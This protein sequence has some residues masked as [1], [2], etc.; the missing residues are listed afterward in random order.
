MALL[1]VLSDV[2]D[3]SLSLDVN[4]IL[5]VAYEIHD[6]HGKS[7]DFRYRLMWMNSNST[8]TGQVQGNRLRLTGSSML[9][10]NAHTGLKQGKEPDPLF[11][12]VLVQFAVPVPVPFPSI[13]NKP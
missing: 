6:R 11:P 13:V 9:Y 7:F 10:R 3:A 8:G 12:I 2:A 5:D 4:G 1:P